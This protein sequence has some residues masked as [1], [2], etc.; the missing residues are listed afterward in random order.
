MIIDDDEVIAYELLAEQ[1]ETGD[2][3]ATS[4]L[5]LL[6]AILASIEAGEP[7]KKTK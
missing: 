1:Q 4:F 6:L 7:L 3:S 5:A 2:E